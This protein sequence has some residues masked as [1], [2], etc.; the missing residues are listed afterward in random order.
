MTKD[1]Q[2]VSAVTFTNH[3]QA[4]SVVVSDP[5]IEKTVIGQ[6]IMPAAFSFVMTATNPAFPMST[7]SVNGE[8][9]MTRIGTGRVEFGDITFTETSTYTY[10]LQEKNLATPGYAYNQRSYLITYEVTDKDGQLTVTRT[11]EQAGQTVTQVLFINVYTA[12]SLPNTGG[13]PSEQDPG[14]SSTNTQPT[15]PTALSLLPNTGTNPTVS[16]VVQQPTPTTNRLPKTGNASSAAYVWVGIMMI[17]LSGMS[18][19]L[20]YRNHRKMNRP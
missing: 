18:C 13:N 20:Y 11:I 14:K 15:N 16:K 6:P 5:P 17:V 4:K 8:K 19:L 12:P 7:G 3:Y 1:S 9:T 2:D 10:V